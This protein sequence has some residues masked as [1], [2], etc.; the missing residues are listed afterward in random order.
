MQSPTAAS[1]SKINREDPKFR[2]NLPM[3]KRRGADRNPWLAKMV[4]NIPW[5]IV[6]PVTPIPLGGVPCAPLLD[7]RLNVH[8]IKHIYIVLV[9]PKNIQCKTYIDKHGGPMLVGPRATAQRAHELRWY[10]IHTSPTSLQML[11]SY[12]PR[13]TQCDDNTLHDPLGLVMNR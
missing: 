13:W 3:V 5:A 12:R 9:F 6:S 2:L 10:W 8:K 4:F 7:P 11:K 1:N